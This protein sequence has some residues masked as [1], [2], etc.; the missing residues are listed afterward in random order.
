MDF[1]TMRKKINTG[2]YRT[3]DDFSRDFHLVMNNCKTYNGPNTA[4]FRSADK[5]LQYGVKAIE[6]ES[7]SV[8]YEQSAPPGPSGSGKRKV[9]GAGASAARREP[10]VKIEEEVDI[11]G[12]DG[13]GAETSRARGPAGETDEWREGSL[14]GTPARTVAGTQQAAT[15]GGSGGKK[16]RE[17]KRRRKA[18][19]G[20]MGIVYAPDGSLAAVHGIPDI[21]HLIARSPPYGSNPQLTV[22]SSHGYRDPTDPNPFEVSERPAAY[23][24]YG[25]YATLGPHAPGSYLTLRDAEYLYSV[26]G[27]ERGEAYAR[28]LWEFVG[29][30]VDGME[31]GPKKEIMQ[32]VEKKLEENALQKVKVEESEEV[33]RLLVDRVVK[34]EEEEGEENEAM[35]IS[36]KEEEVEEE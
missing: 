15:A 34:K 3:M 10:T 28:S 20:E 19:G 17:D 35:K 32:A 31:E 11:L 24:D 16:R 4:Y 8:V 36:A 1:G 13:A 6:R 5:I 12:L 33:D 23:L 22:L 29:G 14:G 21:S 18:G 27:D 25:P 26:F 2:Q 30:I 9:A 7:R